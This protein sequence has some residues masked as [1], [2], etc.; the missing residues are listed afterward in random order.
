M[1]FAKAIVAAIVMVIVI[2]VVAVPVVSDV[3]V[4]RSPQALDSTSVWDNGAF[5]IAKS[6]GSITVDGEVVSSNVFY[7]IGPNLVVMTSGVK[8]FYNNTS[9]TLDGESWTATLEADGDVTITDG[10]DTYTGK[11]DA[12]KTYH[13]VKSGGTYARTTGVDEAL[14]NSDSRIVAGY[15]TNIGSTYYVYAAG[16]AAGQPAIDAFYS[17]ATVTMDHGTAIPSVT[18]NDDDDGTYTLNGVVMKYNGIDWNANCIL[19]PL[20]Y[21]SLV[22]AQGDTIDILVGIIP[23]L[24]AVGVV[25]VLAVEFT[26]RY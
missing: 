22:P 14:V 15:I 11:A 2:V 23:L 18:Y 6:S 3:N 26:R 13:A 25:V 12:S 7:A 24:L 9:H 8:L 4:E 5:E 16:D 21:Y 20:E 10:T 19:I 1:G 17:N